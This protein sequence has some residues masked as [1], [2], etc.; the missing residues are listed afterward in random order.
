MKKNSSTLLASIVL[1]GFSFAHAQPNIGLKV[2]VV[3]AGVNAQYV[4]S[5]VDYDHT[6]KV[7]VLFGAIA[8]WP[9]SK[10]L[11]FR[12]G[13]ELVVKGSKERHR[14]SSFFGGGE[15]D[16]TVGQP[17][18]YIDIPLNLLYA[19]KSGNGKGLLGGGPV[20]SFQLNSNYTRRAYSLKSFDP[21]INIQASYEWPIGFSVNLNHQRSLQN[22]STNKEN[23]R[24]FKNY[25]FGISLGYLF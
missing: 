25:Y 20:A 4:G 22:I 23:V 17:L 13:V 19:M 7:G 21:G 3:I 1:L 15:Y 11:Y 9:L 16:F 24:N 14:G 5:Y 2:G 6:D 8:H 10:S 18:T 12:P